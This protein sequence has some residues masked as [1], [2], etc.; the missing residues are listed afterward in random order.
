MKILVFNWRDIKN[1]EAGG[2]EVH[3]HEILKRLCQKGYEITMVSSNFDGAEKEEYIDGIHII[4]IGNKY[5]MN[6]YALLYYFKLR[7]YKKFDV[8]IDD[9]SK[10]PLYTP[11]YIRKPIIAIVHHMFEKTAQYET[12]IILSTIVRV[13]LGIMTY[14]YKNI[15]IVAVSDSTKSDLISR[16]IPNCNIYVIHNGIDL[17]RYS[18]G[19]KSKNPLVVYFGRV[20]KYK[21]VDHLVEAFYKVQNEIPDLKLIIAGKGDY[22]LL[23]SFDKIKNDPNIQLVGEVSED[24]KVKILQ[25]AWVFV[26]PSVEEGWGITVIEA[27]ACGTPAIG[28]DVPGLR[29]SIKH[30]Y[31][32]LLVRDGDVDS[33]AET[34]KTIISNNDLRVKLSKNAIQW[35][36]K[37]S[38]DKSADEFDKLLDFVINDYNKIKR[39]F[40]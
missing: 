26:N 8:V 14:V 1:P 6:I 31:N 29:D 21:R 3:I 27:N 4:R 16:G 11:L 9:I 12:N 22:T 15:P 38:W 33:L 23:N 32:G 24:D 7:K 35:A 20:K 36:L 30:G 5:L 25:K 13:A 18:P 39:C 2:A 19:E 10:I 28:Y 17:K 34:L 37:F 40:K